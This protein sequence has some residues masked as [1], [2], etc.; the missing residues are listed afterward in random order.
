MGHFREQSTGKVLPA[1]AGRG[2]APA[3]GSGELEP[4]GLNHEHSVTR[5]AGG[6]LAMARWRFLLSRLLKRSQLDRDMDEELQFHIAARAEALEKTGLSSAEALRAA[7]LE[8]GGLERYKEEGRQA[9]K[10]QVLH[11]LQADV[12]YGLRMM[13][14]APG[15]TA[16]AV[17]TLA[18]GIGAN[19]G[20]FG[21]I[22]GLLY[23]PLPYPGESRIAAVHL[24]FSPQNNPR[25]NL[26]LADFADWKNSNTAFEQ[27]AIYSRSRFTLTG[28]GE[29][30][31]VAG[32]AV[33]ADYSSILRMQPILGRTFQ[34]GDDSA[35]SPPQVV[36]SASLW[37]RRF[38]SASDIV[39]RVI[40][41]DGTPSTI[42]G[43][44]REGYGFPLPN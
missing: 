38:G 15:F 7:R 30:E 32:A 40:E 28:S 33:T 16:V 1:D 35:A 41:I 13:R 19:S 26:S 14:K 42:I 20:M 36:I 12:R 37:Q 24:H 31:Q 27:V 10:F 6:G 44:V 2:K 43:V 5:Q 22:Y 39:G 8:F 4:P 18:L 3:P 9:R 34:P 29:A 17:L 23:R 11:D 21:I 25:G